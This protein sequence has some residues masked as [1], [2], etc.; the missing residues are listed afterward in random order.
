MLG[1]NSDPYW[2]ILMA[3]PDAPDDELRWLRG[4]GGLLR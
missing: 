1:V 4:G 3:D 2:V